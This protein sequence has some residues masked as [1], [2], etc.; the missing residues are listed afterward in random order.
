MKK[1][2]LFKRSGEWDGVIYGSF[3]YVI[4]PTLSNWEGYHFEGEYDNTYYF[5]DGEPVKRPDC[6]TYLDGVVLREVLAGSVITIDDEE[7]P[8]S[9]AQ[10]VTLSFP[11]EGKYLV[12]VTP[13]FPYLEKEFTIDYQ[14]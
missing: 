13:P 9:E 3:P 7:Y 8:V 11:F 12:K 1:Y 5:H 10:D 6:P 2:T 14:P 4:A